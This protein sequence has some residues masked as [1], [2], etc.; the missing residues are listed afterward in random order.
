M[1]VCEL[2]WLDEQ[3]GAAIDSLGTVDWVIGSDI[4][5]D[6]SLARPLAETY[7]EFLGTGTTR[8]ILCAAVRNST[9]FGIFIEELKRVNI[10]AVLIEEHTVPAGRLKYCFDV[11]A[12]VRVYEL[13]TKIRMQ[14]PAVK[15]TPMPILQPR[16]EIVQFTER[17]KIC[18]AAASWSKVVS[19]AFGH[20]ADSWDAARF[21]EL[22]GSSERIELLLFI[23]DVESSTIVA[24]AFAWRQEV[25]VG[26]MHWVGVR[27]EHRGVGL[28]KAMVSKILQYW[29]G[30]VATVTLSTESFRTEAI[31]LY[32]SMGFRRVE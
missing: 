6:P 29:A 25:D 16:Y 30:R 24:T 27:P 11:T 5:Y 28:A 7:K 20:F 15:F 1:D 22:Y 26:K 23:R 9:T 18:E 4:V 13:Y 32:E 17:E 31:G 3:R 12:P 2:D 8:A 19:A 21:N 10:H 14:R